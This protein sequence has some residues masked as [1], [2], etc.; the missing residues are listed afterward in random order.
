MPWREVIEPGYGVAVVDRTLDGEAALAA[1]GGIAYL[2]GVPSPAYALELIERLAA[3]A[4]LD[5]HRLHR[6][7]RIRD[8]GRHRY[9]FNYGPDPVDVSALLANHDPVVGDGRLGP[10]GVAIGAKTSPR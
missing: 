4:G 9:V 7:I 6:D 10:C 2:A 5:P 1:K 8:T 3:D